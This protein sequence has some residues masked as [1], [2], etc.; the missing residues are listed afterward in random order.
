MKL[1]KKNRVVQKMKFPNNSNIFIVDFQKIQELLLCMMY[2]VTSIKLR[3]SGS[4]YHCVHLGFTQTFH[5][6]EARPEPGRRTLTL[7]D[8]NGNTVV[9][10]FMVLDNQ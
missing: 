5:E 10:R 8:S 7:V 9:R 6:M 1:Q 4:S 2:S 3:K